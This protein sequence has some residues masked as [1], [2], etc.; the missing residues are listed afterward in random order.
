MSPV[1][2]ANDRI[3]FSRWLPV[4]FA[5]MINLEVTG[6]EDYD[7]FK[8]GKSSV[9]RTG[10]SFAALPTGLVVLEQTLNKH[11]KGSGGLK[12]KGNNGSCKDQ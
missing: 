2:Y 7:E 5:E 6:K 9:N 8:A 1:F 4:Y 3:N 12:G 10:I 11:S